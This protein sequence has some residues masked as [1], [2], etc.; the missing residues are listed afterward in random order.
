MVVFSLGALPACTVNNETDCGPAPVLATGS[1]VDLATSCVALIEYEGRTYSEGCL[2]VHPSRLGP[3]FLRDG[4]ETGYAGARRIKGVPSEEAFVLLGRGC[5]RR[6][7]VATGD[8]FTDADSDLVRQPVD[9]PVVLSLDDWRVRPRE[10]IQMRVYARHLDHWLYGND[11]VLGR[12]VRGRWRPLYRLFVS[13]GQRPTYTRD[14]DALTTLEGYEGPGP[15]R[16][17]I[18]PVR[19]GEY[20]IRKEFFFNGDSRDAPT[21]TDRVVAAATLRVLP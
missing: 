11:A 17:R 5:G 14:L 12:E 18:P 15:L 21:K 8:G 4:G 7:V 20:E 2:A 3:V 1:G 6:H 13:P 9:K 19:P 16:V 10:V